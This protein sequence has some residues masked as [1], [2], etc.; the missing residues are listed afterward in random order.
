MARLYGAGRSDQVTAK[1]ELWHRS[2]KKDPQV[3]DCAYGYQK[4]NYE[5]AEEVEAKRRQKDDADEKS[6]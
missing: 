6:G 3:L 2:R 1:K 5:E 4:Q